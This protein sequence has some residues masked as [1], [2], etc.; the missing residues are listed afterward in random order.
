MSMDHVDDAGRLYKNLVHASEPGEAEKEIEI[1]F[2]EEELQDYE[3]AHEE[4]VR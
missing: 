2:Q 1:W 4:H 3:H